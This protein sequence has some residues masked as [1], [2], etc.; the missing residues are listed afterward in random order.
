MKK[1]YQAPSLLLDY[2]KSGDI[3]TASNKDDN[4]DGWIWSE[5]ELE[6]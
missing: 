2:L 6:K 3:L 5:E 4:V 1:I